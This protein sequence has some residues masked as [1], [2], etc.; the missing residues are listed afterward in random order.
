MSAARRWKEKMAKARRSGSRRLS[1]A[2]EKADKQQLYTAAACVAGGAAH[3]YARG[4]GQTEFAG[5]DI[6]YGIG[7][8]CLAG[9]QVMERNS[10]GRSIILGLG[11]G[12]LAATMSESAEK[13]AKEAK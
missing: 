4:S 13:M 9:S 10:T 7:A 1:R 5:Y 12:A 2:K 6:G 8:V 11:A 3:G